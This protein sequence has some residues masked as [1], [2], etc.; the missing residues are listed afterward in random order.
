MIQLTQTYDNPTELNT[1]TINACNKNKNMNILV[2]VLV[3]TQFYPR[4][5]L[6]KNHTIY[7]VVNRDES[8]DRSRKTNGP[9]TIPS[10]LEIDGSYYDS[11]L[12]KYSNTS[13]LI[14]CM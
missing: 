11:I 12:A 10:V 13:H 3:V 5:C 7:L 14:L 8:M 9:N 1:V 4:M 2:C 6:K